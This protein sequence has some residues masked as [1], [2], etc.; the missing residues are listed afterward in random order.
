[1]SYL[2]DRYEKRS[3]WNGIFT[4]KLSTITF[5]GFKITTAKLNKRNIFLYCLIFKSL[6]IHLKSKL[7]LNTMHTSFETKRIPTSKLILLNYAFE[8]A[9]LVIVDELHVT[10]NLSFFYRDI[11]KWNCDICLPVDLQPYCPNIST[12]LLFAAWWLHWL[13][14]HRHYSKVL[15]IFITFLLSV[16]NTPC[17]INGTWSFFRPFW[18]NSFFFKSYK[19]CTISLSLKFWRSSSFFSCVNT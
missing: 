12:N 8:K 10:L 1:M 14:V 6:Q 3:F 5:L 2:F 9:H 7:N 19:Y 16:E 13:S 18:F 15:Y 11:L 4:N 17:N